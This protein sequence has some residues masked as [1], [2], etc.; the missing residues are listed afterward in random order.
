MESLNNVFSWISANPGWGGVGVF[1]I[2]FFESLA[3]VGLVLPGAAMMFGIG[4][5]V[6]TDIL[7]LGPTLVWAAAGAIAG[8]AVSFWLGRHYHMQLKTMWPLRN[9]P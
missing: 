7:P 2:A 8:D 5:L 3:L 9:H 1:L 4:A 6:G